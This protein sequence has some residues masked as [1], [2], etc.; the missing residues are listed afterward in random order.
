MFFAHVHPMLM[1]ILSFHRSNKETWVEMILI[2]VV[3]FPKRETGDLEA[4]VEIS[5]DFTMSVCGVVAGLYC[6]TSTLVFGKFCWGAHDVED[7]R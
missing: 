5:G 4:G 3:S 1:S 2:I 7:I 6:F